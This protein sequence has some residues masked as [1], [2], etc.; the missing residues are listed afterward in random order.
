M[1]LLNAFLVMCVLIAG[2]FAYSL[3]H[4]TRGMERKVTK[5]EKAIDAEREAIK[6]AKAEWSSLIRPARLQELAEQTLDVVPMKAT[7]MITIEEIATRVPAEPIV[8]LEENNAD[9]IGDII[10]KMR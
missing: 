1:K 6:F 7:Q 8:K 10:E 2:F 5:L 9:P 3:E 4:Q